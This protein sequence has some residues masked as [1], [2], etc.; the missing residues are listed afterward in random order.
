MRVI[1]KN[2]WLK[3]QMTIDLL[4]IGDVPGDPLGDLATT[5]NRLSVWTIAQDESNLDQ[6]IAAIASTRKKIDHFSYAIFDSELLVTPKISTVVIPGITLDNEA[7]AWH[8]DITNLSG[9]KI[10]N[11]A[12]IIL[13]N[14]KIKTKL[15]KEIETLLKTAITTN[16][17]PK[18]IQ[19]KFFENGS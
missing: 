18:E 16:K 8:Q 4:A 3:D 15:K 7:N 17:L 5:E 10:I 6:I 11:L 2:R 1:R 9:M 13:E 12:K 19:T 14:G